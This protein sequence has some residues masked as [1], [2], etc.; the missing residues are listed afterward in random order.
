MNSNNNKGGMNVKLADII[1]EQGKNV[2]VYTNTTI[3]WGWII[4]VKGKKDMN[5]W[6]TSKIEGFHLVRKWKKS[7]N[8]PPSGLKK[9]FLLKIAILEMGWLSKFQSHR[10]W[11]DAH[12]SL[13][14]AQAP[15]N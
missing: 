5:K 9:I 7:S 11:E 4:L 14:A 8:G 15:P 3:L 2:Y 6:K 1:N 12:L 13:G 10:S